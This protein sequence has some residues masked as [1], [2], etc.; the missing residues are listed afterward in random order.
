MMRTA[1]EVQNK[2]A[3]GAL[4]DGGATQAD[5]DRNGSREQ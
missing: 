3:E 4:L 5:R 2:R 1:S